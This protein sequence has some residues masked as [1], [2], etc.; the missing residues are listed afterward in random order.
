MEHLKNDGQ[1]AMKSRNSREGR[2]CGYT[3]S[4]RDEGRRHVRSKTARQVSAGA[5]ARAVVARLTSEAE[6]RHQMVLA[7]RIM[8]EDK[9][10][11]RELARR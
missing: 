3:T 8:D 5:A 11:L 4:P 2:Y 1:P 10:M 7:A 9:D 6:E